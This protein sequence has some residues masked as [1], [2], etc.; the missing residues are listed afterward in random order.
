MST[1]KDYSGK[2]WPSIKRRSSLMEKVIEKVKVLSAFIVLL[3]QSFLPGTQ[4]PVPSG[5]V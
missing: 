3:W 4:V 5:R 2:C 1:L